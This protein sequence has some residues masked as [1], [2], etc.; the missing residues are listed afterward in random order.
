MVR[1][2]KFILALAA[3]VLPGTLG[4]VQAS[5]IPKNS[6]DQRGLRPLPERV[7]EGMRLKTSPSKSAVNVERRGDAGSPSDETKARKEM[8]R[9][10]KD[11]NRDAKDGEDKQNKEKKDGE[12][13]KEKKDGEKDKKDKEK[14]DKEK[15]DSEKNKEK[16]NKGRDSETTKH[17]DRRDRPGQTSSPA[18]TATPTRYAQQGLRRSSPRQTTSSRQPL[19]GT[20]QS[21][22]RPPPRSLGKFIPRS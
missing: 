3:V 1:S 19:P 12:K 17:K 20:S 10:E 9:S 14:K 7:R 16:K 4:L 21:R 18:P 15:K 5:P 22:A 11:K 13:D 8:D 6:L 2:C